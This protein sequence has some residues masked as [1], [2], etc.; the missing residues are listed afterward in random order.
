MNEKK[1]ISGKIS[2]HGNGMGVP[3]PEDIERRARELAMIDERDPDQFT[4]ADWSQAREEL[5]GDLETLPPEEDDKNI[6][7]EDEWEV[8]PDDRGH[9]VPRP[10]VEEE[11]ETIG[12][13]LV[14]DGREE[15]AHDQM[16]EARRE[17]LQQEG[18]TT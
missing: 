4:D 12:E 7:L 13:H 6:K 10:G 1:P 16:L 17:E 18:G 15:A 11:D 9:R 8:T 3:A 14:S 5:L 2:L